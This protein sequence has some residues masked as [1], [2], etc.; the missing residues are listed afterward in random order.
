MTVA[1]FNGKEVGIGHVGDSR[2]YLYRAGELSQLTKDH[3]FVQSLIDEGRITEEDSRV[4]PHRN[5]ILRAVDGV[6]ETEP[7]R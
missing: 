4:H 3:T 2:G 7:D 1:V 6:H 5:L